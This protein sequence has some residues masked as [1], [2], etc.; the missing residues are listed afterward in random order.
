MSQSTKKLIKNDKRFNMRIIEC[1]MDKMWLNRAVAATAMDFLSWV[2][3]NF[4]EVSPGFHFK[5]GITAWI[6][7]V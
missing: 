2:G 5:P 4:K 7:G 3:R 1:M 6:Y